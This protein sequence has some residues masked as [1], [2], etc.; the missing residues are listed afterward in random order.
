VSKIKK[1]I[2]MKIKITQLIFAILKN[3][4]LSFFGIRVIIGFMEY[5]FISDVTVLI[6]FCIFVTVSTM[7]DASKCFK[8]E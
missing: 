7:Y 2:K 4:A 3:F 8:D 5:Y 1:I 6:L